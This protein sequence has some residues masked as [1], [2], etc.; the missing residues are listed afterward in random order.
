[1]TRKPWRRRLAAIAL[2]MMPRP[3][4]PT[5]ISAACFL[6]P[7]PSSLQSSQA[8]TAHPGR[9]R[10]GQCSIFFMFLWVF[11]VASRWI[12]CCRVVPRSTERECRRRRSPPSTGHRT[13]SGRARGPG[14]QIGSGR[15]PRVSGDWARLV[16]LA[17]VCR[18]HQTDLP[19]TSAGCGRT[20]RAEVPLLYVP[21]VS[22][23]CSKPIG[24]LLFFTW[25]STS[26]LELLRTFHSSLGTRAKSIAATEDFF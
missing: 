17:R 23:A 25:A 8:R 3:R 10:P 6:P 5:S 19:A 13:V 21:R 15:G 18:G 2:P 11:L 9:L 4:N 26:L 7:L 1:V 16:V 12:F 24:L 14:E 22:W 20:A